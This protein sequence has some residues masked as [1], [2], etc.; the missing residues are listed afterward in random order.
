MR[1]PLPLNVNPFL[2]L[3]DDR[4][5]TDMCVRAASLI[6]S[7]VRFLQALRNETLEPDV[8]HMGEL[9]DKRWFKNAVTLFAPRKIAYFAA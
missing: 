9:G 2:K 8:F 3:V 5:T 4:R 1:G 6:V 7:S